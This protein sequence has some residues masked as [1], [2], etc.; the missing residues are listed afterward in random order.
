MVHNAERHPGHIAL[1]G[2]AGNNSRE[3]KTAFGVL[4]INGSVGSRVAEEVSGQPA[5]FIRSAEQSTI[6]LVDANHR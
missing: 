4:R 6:F 2:K 1:R 5:V 3:R